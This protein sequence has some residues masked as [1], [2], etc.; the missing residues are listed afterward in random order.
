MKKIKEVLTNNKKVIENYFFMT[1]LQLLNSFFYLLIYPYVIR[2][3]EMDAWGIFI[4]ASS[5]AAYFIFIINFGFDLPATK[6]VAESTHK[7]NNLNKIF[8]Q[9]LYAKNL[10]FLIT[11]VLF[12]IFLITV[13]FFRT[14]KLLFTLSYLQIYSY[15]LVPQWF[16]QGIQNMKRVT[17]IQFVTKMLSL[18]FIFLLVKEPSDI[19]V[20]S[21]IITS[22]SLIGAVYIFISTIKEYKFEFCTICAS[23][24]KLLL[25]EAQPFFFSSFAGT[26]KEYSIPIIIGSYLGMRDVAIYDLANKIIIVPRVI[27]SSINAA[28]FPK[29]ITNINDY[30]VKKILKY[31][32]ILSTIAIVLI[33]VFGK[34]AVKLLGGEE[35]SEAYFLSL[36][37]SVTIMSWLV[38]GAYINFVFLPNNLQKEI[39][40][41]QTIAMLSFFLICFAGMLFANKN[42]FIVGFAIAISGILEILYCVYVTKKSLLLNS[43]QIIIKNKLHF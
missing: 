41:N 19:Y 18:P 36:F 30:V 5:F 3:V 28:I 16:F 31:E 34:H 25:L 37:L 26:I 43:K 32:Y 29:L 2:K 1:A 35:M 23:E 20:Y 33:V 42:I 17:L 14:N 9:I 40:K 38:V 21:F 6:K 4:F 22:T 27:F 39:V 10:L 11:T 15:I 13:P 12:I 8:V 7:N 24:I